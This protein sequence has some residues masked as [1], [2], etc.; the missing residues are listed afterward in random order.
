MYLF[1]SMASKFGYELTTRVVRV[2]TWD[3]FVYPAQ[4]KVHT[5]VH[6]DHTTTTRQSKIYSPNHHDH[7]N[8]ITPRGCEQ[9]ITLQSTTTTQPPQQST[10]CVKKTDLLWCSTK[11][12]IFGDEGGRSVVTD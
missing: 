10:L 11:Y 2:G 6:H 4:S 1:S 3:T 8:T 7:T 12:Y 9:S 5:P